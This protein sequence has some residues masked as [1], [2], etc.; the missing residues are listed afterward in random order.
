[1]SV[2]SHVSSS[3]VKR[4]LRNLERQGCTIELTKVGSYKVRT[5]DG[6][7]VVTHFSLSDRR[8]WLNTVALFR[9]HGLELKL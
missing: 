2:G 4:M 7:L 6:R 9:R 3:K 8:G 1:V 5:T